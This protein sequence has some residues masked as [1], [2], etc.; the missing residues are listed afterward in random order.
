VY[1]VGQTVRVTSTS[2]LSR[3]GIAVGHATDEVGATGLTVI[4]GIDQPLRAGVAIY[5]RATGTR[6]LHTAS[7]DHGVEGRVDAIVLAGGSAYGLGAVTGV[8][9][10]MEERGRGLSVGGGVVPIIPA[11]VVFD[12]APLGRF[13]ARPTPDM[14]YE[15]TERASPIVVEGSIGAGTGTT[16]GKIRGPAFAMK[17]GFGCAIEEL[18]NAEVTVGAMTVVN[19]FGDIRDAHGELL[20]GARE[21]RG[22]FADALAMLRAGEIT[23]PVTFGDLAMRN[24]TL[25]VVAANVPLSAVELTQLARAAGAAFFKRITP[26]GT[27]FDG[28]VVFA[29]APMDGTRWERGVEGAGRRGRFAPMIIEALAVAALERAIERAVRLARGRDGVPGLADDHGH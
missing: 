5:G 3:L 4:R 14:A 29:V 8:T 13:D 16:V 2:D 6:E 21:E 12:L 22:G 15:A 25:A 20:A 11:A 24:T 7:P 28:D 27:S 17:G 10:W 26:A 1:A 23:T 18:P 19:A 9:R